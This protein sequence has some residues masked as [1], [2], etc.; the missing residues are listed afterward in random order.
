[1]SLN[2]RQ[3]SQCTGWMQ[4]VPGRRRGWR[5]AARPL[6]RRGDAA[7]TERRGCPL[8]VY[9]LEIVV[10]GVVLV[11]PSQDGAV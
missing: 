9:R 8:K 7:F 3:E 5:R 1:M 11:R 4:R 6:R 2:V 10:F